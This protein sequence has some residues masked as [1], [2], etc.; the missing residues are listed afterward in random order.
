MQCSARLHT[1][2]PQLFRHG[3]WVLACPYT[4]YTIILLSQHAPWACRSP[5]INPPPSPAAAAFRPFYSNFDWLEG[6][7]SWLA[8]N[9]LPY[10]AYLVAAGTGTADCLPAPPAFLPA[11]HVVD[12]FH[13]S[14]RQ[15]VCPS[16]RVRSCR[17]QTRMPRMVPAPMD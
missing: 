8:T 4:K 7:A 13:P 3:I 10:L 12:L 1:L 2:G 9:L 5:R 14:V 17:L 6:L 11:T 15:T 16:I